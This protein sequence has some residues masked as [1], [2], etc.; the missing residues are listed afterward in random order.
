MT[1]G[2]WVGV[3]LVGGLVAYVWYE[4]A[5]GTGA[6]NQWLTSALGSTTGS[7]AS[8][9]SGTTASGLYGTI[10]NALAGFENVAS[11]HNNPGGIC[12]SFDANGNC[13]GPET[14]A[15]IEDG[16]GAAET[17]ISNWIAANPGITVAGFVQKWSGATGTVL[18]NYVQH[19]ADALG[20]N[21]NDPIANAGSDGDGGD[22]DDG[23]DA[24]GG[25]SA[26][27]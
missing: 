18:Q 15:S 14:F 21:P 25:D 27:D 17:K 26:D 16:I 8:A 11:Q 7:T 22:G 6:V 1:R 24:L 2:E 5:S 4:Y 23:A 19:V 12:G 10:L 9:D 13:L 20:L 3:A